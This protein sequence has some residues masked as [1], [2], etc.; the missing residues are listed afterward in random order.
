LKDS[1]KS[2]R[3]AIHDYVWELIPLPTDSSNMNNREGIPPG[4]DG[5]TESTVEISEEDSL[6]NSM[7][8][9]KQREDVSIGT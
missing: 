9:W 2:V 3:E 6:F 7:K 8:I 4:M 5:V 1:V